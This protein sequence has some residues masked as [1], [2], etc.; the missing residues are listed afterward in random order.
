[1]AIGNGGKGRTVF[2]V[3]FTGGAA[4]IKRMVK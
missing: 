3:T 1:M 4:G 2:V